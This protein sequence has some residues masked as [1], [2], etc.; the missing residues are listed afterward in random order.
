M[1]GS[2]K[3]LTENLI[4]RLSIDNP[5]IDVKRTVNNAKVSDHHAILPTMETVGQD[6]SELSDGEKAILSLITVKLLC[7]AA[8]SCVYEAVTA[9]IS[10][11]GYNFI[12]KGKKDIT[13]GWKDVEDKAKQA[14]NIGKGKEKDGDK[15]D[16]KA[17]NV[18]QNQTFE[19]AACNI[20]ERLTSPPKHYT[21][22][23]LLSAMETAGNSDYDESSDVEKKGLGT[24]ATRANIIETLI[25]RGYM[26]RQ[27]KNLI[28]TDKGDNLIK[29]VPESV[30][31]AK[32]TAEWETVLQKIAKGEAS[33]R[34][35]MSDIEDFIRNL[36][37]EY[38]SAPQGSANMFSAPKETIGKCPK[39]GGEVCETPKAYSCTNDREKCGFIIWKSVASKAISETQIKK[40]LEKG[41]SDKI[42]GFKSKAGKEFEA[43]LI[44]KG[45]FTVGFEF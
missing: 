8:K 45:D 34:K 1:A 20:A 33:E 44:L 27:K 22:D 40:L 21:E 30:K 25:K 32:L 28:A 3:T 35:F 31:S 23:T 2:A 5:D 24:P 39:C 18:S 19:N 43:A 9:N 14:L 11:E 41:K 6:I 4:N 38:S 42:K 7:A 15:E 37:A 36:V 17:L 29:T 16:E 13:P 12:T 26:E 10:C